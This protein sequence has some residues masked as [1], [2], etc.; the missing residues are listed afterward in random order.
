MVKSRDVPVE[1][2]QPVPKTQPGDWS[3]QAA[4]GG[5]TGHRSGTEVQ[6]CLTLSQQPA[7]GGPSPEPG[8]ELLEEA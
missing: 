8:P 6:R 2:D 7:E 4:K 1:P 5:G 3:V